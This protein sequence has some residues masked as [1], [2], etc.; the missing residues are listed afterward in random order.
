[1]IQPASKGTPPPTPAKPPS[2]P[3]FTKGARLSIGSLDD[4][5]LS[6]EAQYNP[7]ELQLDRPVPW[8]KHNLSVEGSSVQARRQN[9][10][11]A[12]AGRGVL[13]LEF[14]GAESRTIT[15][16]LLFDDVETSPEKRT[17]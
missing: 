15:I 11:A 14:G 8:A 16:D 5:G 12:E 9:Q 7:K 13:H 17:L 4:T 3:P 1:M 10:A 6:V 2:A